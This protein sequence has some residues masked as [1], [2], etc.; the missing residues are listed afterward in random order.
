VAY[1]LHKSA[2]YAFY[3][4]V[5]LIGQFPGI[6][7]EL[8]DSAEETIAAAGVESAGSSP[9]V[10]QHLRER[11][12]K[13]PI[14]WPNVADVEPV[15]ALSRSVAA[16]D[17]VGRAVFAGNLSANKVDFRYLHAVLDVG[18]ELNLA[19]PISEGGGSAG[20]EVAALVERGAKYHGLKTLEGLAEIYAGAS[21]GLIPYHLNA[22]T[23]GVSPL[24]TF[25]YLAA[26][27]VVVSTPI[28]AVEP[29]DDDVFVC[30]SIE[31]FSDTL[32]TLRREAGPDDLS[33][34]ARI[35]D[36]HSWTLRGVEGREVVRSA[37][38]TELA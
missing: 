29:L 28:P 37:V 30:D 35:A 5:D 26:G 22:Y 2:D 8:I 1:D 33:R 34:R 19:G 32:M 21:V 31:R 13:D 16:E 7:A 23:R 27:L 3:H 38:A 15:A 20:E 6:S 25:E 9:V 14:Y 12:F 24:K 11:G 4:C 10:V 36:A 18:Y 17:R